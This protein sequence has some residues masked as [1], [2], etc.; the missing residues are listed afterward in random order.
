MT[1]TTHHTPDGRSFERPV[2]PDGWYWVRK[3]GWYGETPDWTLAEWRQS[4]RAWYST[5]YSGI[6]DSQIVEHGPAVLPP[7]TEAMRHAAKDER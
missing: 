6:P 3:D 1:D 7:N 4:C 5:T 2:R